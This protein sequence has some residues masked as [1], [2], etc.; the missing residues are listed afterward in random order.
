M[1]SFAVT[2][3]NVSVKRLYYLP[4]SSMSIFL[5]SLLRGDWFLMYT[6]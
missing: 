4:E 3:L 1:V 2:I 6:R 5:P